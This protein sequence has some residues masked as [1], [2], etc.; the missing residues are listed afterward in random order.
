MH[1]RYLASL[2]AAA[3]VG[4]VAMTFVQPEQAAAAG[5]RASAVGAWFGIARPCTPP[6]GVSHPTVNQ[7]VCSAACDGPCPIATY[8]VPEV[9]MMPTLLADGTMLADDFGSVGVSP[10]GFPIAGD[11]HT[12]SHGKWVSQGAVEIAGVRLERY[13]ASYV[14]FQGRPPGF[15]YN[16]ASPVGFFHGSVRPRFV[17]FFDKSN[18]D[19]MVGYL[20]PYLYNYTNSDGIVNLRP[21]TPFPAVDP[22]A[23]LPAACN[24]ADFGAGPYC[25]GTLQITL[26]RIPA[27]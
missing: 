21:G 18:P 2:V 25:L 7:T 27:E 17:T 23:P 16:A 3:V 26:R 4:A 14:S 12:T 24:P 10:P 15:P 9:T 20:Q 6:G 8:P 11:G 13:Q 19:V 5:G 22:T 1:N